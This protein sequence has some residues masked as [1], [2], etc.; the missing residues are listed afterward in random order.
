VYVL[1]KLLEPGV[2]LERR[3]LVWWQSREPVGV[4]GGGAAA[5]AHRREA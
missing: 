5:H 1:K 4:Y 3:V 2:A